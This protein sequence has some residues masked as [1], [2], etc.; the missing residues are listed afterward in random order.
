MH[1]SQMRIELD[2]QRA[3]IDDL[4]AKHT[5]LNNLLQEKNALLIRLRND[6]GRLK[7]DLDTCRCG[8]YERSK[9]RDRK[10]NDYDVPME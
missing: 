7:H 10:F 3:V 2:E 9:E 1:K 8:A 5:S 6:N 4:R